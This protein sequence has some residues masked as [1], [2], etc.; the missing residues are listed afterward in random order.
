MVQAGDSNKKIWL[1][2]FGYDSSTV[3]VPGFE[4]STLHL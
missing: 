2:E 1:T 4:Y 3:A